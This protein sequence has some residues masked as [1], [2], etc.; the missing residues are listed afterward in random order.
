MTD[1]EIQFLAQWFWSRVPER[2][3]Y[4]RNLAAPVSWSLPLAIVTLPHLGIAKL[5]VWL[6]E[7]GIQPLVEHADRPLRACLVA[8]YGT[9]F[10]FLDGTDPEDERRFSLA[11]E[12]AHFIV[13]YLRPRTDALGAFGDTI[14]PV[15]DG[16]RAPTV[17]E[18]LSSVLR[19]LKL[20]VYD[21]LMSRSESGAVENGNILRIEDNADRLA[22]E[23]L[24]PR[25]LVQSKIRSDETSQE[26]CDLLVNH[27]GLP[28]TIAEQ[29]ARILTPRRAQ[30]RTFQQW[31]GE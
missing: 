19:G 13:D 14:L 9:G 26:I 11:H 16:E 18:R 29:Y 28:I 1:G 20:G 24:A 17:E 6:D 22:L 4:P 25:K 3:A 12:I 10:V 30:K 5:R 2:G 15:L 7:N 23:I 8:S 21:H 31:L 27:F